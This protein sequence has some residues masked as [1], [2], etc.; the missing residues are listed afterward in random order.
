MII[1]P[2]RYQTPQ[3]ENELFDLLH[4]QCALAESCCISIASRPR[5]GPEF[6]KL[7][8]C[9]GHIESCLREVA[10]H[11]A[12]VRWLRLIEP[13]VEVQKRAQKWLVP[14]SVQGKKLFKLLADNMR[15]LREVAE[16]LR[17]ARPPNLGLIDEPMIGGART[18]GRPMQVSKGAS[19]A[20]QGQYD[21]RDRVS[22]DDRP[23]ILALYEE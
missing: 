13:I 5:S 11:R 22:K 9:L 6:T 16:T 3:R 1:M 8:A 23:R 15:A 7:M 21:V 19:P 17:H 18:S 2:E 4:D 12:D 14:V 20:L 10:K